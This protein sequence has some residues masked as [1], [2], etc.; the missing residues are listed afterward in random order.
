M[1][2][3]FDQG[4]DKV[5]VVG[6]DCA[7]VKTSHLRAAAQKL[8]EG[9]NVLGPDRRGGVWL[10]GLHRKDF[11]AADIKNLRWGGEEL[12]ADLSETLPRLDFLVSLQDVNTLGDLRRAWKQVRAFFG[13][14]AD[15]IFATIPVLTG[16][17]GLAPR[18]VTSVAEGRGPPR[19]LGL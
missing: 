8:H 17:A 12:F 11:V 1:Q 13:D 7:S 10:I 16:A 5:I 18:V 2:R 9:H 19:P 6:N 4:F 3:V 15:L 14:L